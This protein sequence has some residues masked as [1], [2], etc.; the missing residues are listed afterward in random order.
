MKNIKL[1][2]IFQ[3]L[4]FNFLCFADT[5]N[6]EDNIKK[7]VN[8]ISYANQEVCLYG[9][10]KWPAGYNSLQLQNTFIQ[11]Q[12]DPQK[13]LEKVPYDFTNKTVLDVGTNQGGMLFFLKD[14]IKYGIGVD[15]NTKLIN[16]ANKI[17]SSTGSHNLDFYSFDLQSENL[18]SLL[19]FLPDKKVDICFFLAM[20]KW[21]ENWKDVI[22]F[23][24]N[25]SDCMLFESNVKREN[26]E[27]WIS[28]I[29]KKYKSVQYINHKEDDQLI[30]NKKK[31]E[32]R[33]LFLCKK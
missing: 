5:K 2:L 20:C 10:K 16:A 29:K 30:L 11:G 7:I 18:N 33:K 19:N 14:K 22:N 12:R 23:L 4:L 6:S 13:R 26:Q 27:E 25:I 28:F 24:Y 21:V 15:Y 3:I 17:K 1:C 31:K 8:L 32:T 9:A